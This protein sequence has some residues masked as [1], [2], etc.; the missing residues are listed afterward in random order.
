L[1]KFDDAL[2]WLAIV[3]DK[4]PTCKVAPKAKVYWLI[5]MSGKIGGLS[6]LSM[7]Y[8]KGATEA[9]DTKL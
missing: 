7:D 9:P 6:S 5:I 4:H 3:A 1:E 2:H 8:L